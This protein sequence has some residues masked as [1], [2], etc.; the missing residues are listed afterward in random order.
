MDFALP[1]SDFNLTGGGTDN[2]AVDLAHKHLAG[3]D[4]HLAFNAGTADRRLRAQQWH[5]LALHVRPHQRTAHIIILQQ[6]DEPR[7]HT[8][9][10]PH[11]PVPTTPPTPP[12]LHNSTP[13]PS[14]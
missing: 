2:L 7:S 12:S 13:S 1:V 3:V 6:R 10:L 8:P 14:H 4:G 11:H 9:I 5:G